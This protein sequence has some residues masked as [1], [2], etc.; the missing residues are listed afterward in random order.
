MLTEC[1]LKVLITGRIFFFFP[2]FFLLIL[3]YLYE[4]TAIS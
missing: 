3:L 1:I 4:M 2:D